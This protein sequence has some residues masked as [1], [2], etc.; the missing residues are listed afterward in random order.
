MKRFTSLILAIMLLGCMMLP[1]GAADAANRDNLKFKQDGTFKIIQVA[2]LQEGFLSSPITQDFLYDLAKKERPDLFVLTG[3]N[4]A[5]GLTNLGFRLGSNIAVKVSIDAFMRVFDRIYCD[6]GIPVTMVYGNHDNEDHW[7]S[8]A[9]Q[10]KLY[11]KHKSFIGWADSGADKGTKDNLGEHYGT[12]NL[13]IKDSAGKGPIFNLWLFDSG[14]NDERGGY[15]CVQ[16]PQIDWFKATNEAVGKLPS[17]AFQHIMVPEV[18]DYLTPANPGDENS[19]SREF[20]DAGDNVTKKYVSWELPAGVPGVMREPPGPGKYNEGQYAA[21]TGAGNVLALFV[22]HDH[23]NTYEITVQGGLDLVCSPG[24]GYGP[25]G[26]GDL[27]GVRVITL[28]ESSLTAYETSTLHYI[29]YYGDSPLRR[30]RAEMAQEMNSW[31][32]LLDVFSF[33]PLFWLIGLFTK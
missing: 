17:I 22:G 15:S 6:F 32:A 20:I 7:F 21:L 25:Y 18:Y 2:D 27:R 23:V 28:N 3:D 10:F 4:I 14:S 24:T 33:K 9:E 26:D 1:V 5:G 30:A 31:A 8:R 13:L 19:F 11:T 12:H 16:K 29:S